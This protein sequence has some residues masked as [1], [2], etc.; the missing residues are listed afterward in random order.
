MRATRWW[1][2]G[3]ASL[4]AL[5][6]LAGAATAAAPTAATGPT[7]AVGSTTA[8]VTGTVSP[9]G[10]AT[11]WTIE[12]GTST[13][14]GSKTAA[15]SAGSGTAATNVSAQL[16]GL[17]AGTTYH[18]RLVAT[19]TT[20]TSTGA[21]AV[22]TT[23]SPPDVTTGGASSITTSSATLNGTV[24]PNGRA[25]TY[26]FDYGT[27]TSYGTKTA[28]RSAGSATTAQSAAVGI[29]GLQ[30][31]QTYHYRLVATSDAGTTVGKDASFTTSGAPAVVTGDVT[32]VTPA[33][34]TLRGAVT[35]NG[36]S[37]TWWFE[38]GTSTSYSAKT[39]NQGA[40]SGTTA[41]SVAAGIRSLKPATTYHYRLVAQNSKGKTFGGDRTFATTGAPSVQTGAAQSVAS[42]SATLTGVLD[43]HGRSTTWW[44]E[45]GTSTS[46]GKSTGSKGAGSKAGTQGVSASVTG[47]TP[48]TTY[49]FRL[50]AKSDAGTS[51]GTDGTFTATGVTLVAAAKD[52]VYG[53]RITLSG[54][55]PTH[56]ANEQVVVYV[57][58]FGEGSF[59]TVA[60]ILTGAGGTW[61]YIAR[62]QI[63]TSYEASWRGGVSAALT[64]AV[65]PR[66]TF[67]RLRN[68][69]F[70]A[71][72]RGGRSFAH[73]LV[74]LQRRTSL[75]WRTVK[76]VRLGV[77][78]RIEFR[79]TLPKGRSTLRVAFSVNQAGTGYLGGFSKSLSLT[80]R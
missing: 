25:T 50:M 71:S 78:S 19:N 12:Y 13:A 7:T 24:D 9:G 67:T 40:G 72:V 53:G 20:A 58:P 63:A 26:Y 31:N 5:A 21:D 55:V 38:Y 15:K 60:T 17:N 41:R 66:V 44:F 29:S 52:V 69:H 48:A 73:R 28:A 49:H 56:T 54:V 62:P 4:L 76:R 2:A 11:S 70:V 6:T 47:L 79:A 45:Y 18:Y 3:A 51:R 14:Y 8:T 80:R 33:S 16:S 68:G 10:Q 36:L 35:A 30:A 65:H 22:F 57:Q 77:R 23:L 75:G 64:V 74:Q 1:T 46:Y 27:S 39:S 61:S 42:D 34:A 43:T 37:T 32:S 59:R